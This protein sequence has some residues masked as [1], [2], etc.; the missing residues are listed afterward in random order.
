MGFLLF[1]M[2]DGNDKVY[3]AKVENIIS[4][5]LI[6]NDKFILKRYF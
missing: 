3:Q 1:E 2:K 6:I 4:G 5:I